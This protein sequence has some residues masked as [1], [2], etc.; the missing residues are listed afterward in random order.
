MPSW[1]KTTVH[2]VL[3]AALAL[4]LVRDAGA[5]PAFA[6][7]YKLSCSTCHAPFPKLK[8]YGDDFAGSGF[9]LKE[10]EKERDYVTAGDDLMW[11]NRYFPVA[12]RFEAFARIDQ[13]KEANNDLET[14]WGLKLMSG[15]TLFKNIGYYF[16][17]YLSE[18]GEVSGIEDAYIHFDNLFRSELDILVGQFQTSDPLMKRELRLT[19]EDYMI[20]KQRVGLVRTNLAYDR[21]VMLLFGIEGTGTDVAGMVVNGNGKPQAGQNEKFDNDAFKNFGLRVKQSIGSFMSVGGFYYTGKERG[22]GGEVNSLSYWGPD[23]NIGLGPVEITVQYLERRDSDPLY[24]GM[25][26]IR[27]RGAV[28]EMILAPQRDRSRFYITALYN[29]IDSEQDEWPDDVL[30]QAELE[31]ISYE[32]ATLSGTYLVARNLRLVAEYTR[33]LKHNAGRFV[34]GV[35]SGF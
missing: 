6:R 15:G 24:N 31:R 27:T 20:Y 3:I 25:G 9:V 18:A 5:I 14:P 21:G 35:V 11:L 28:A 22:E 16:Y 23:V 8:P 30:S 32:S 12:V 1:K 4:V 7:R 13:E 26:V 29:W 33:D 2:A 34:M 17:F 10:E 19:F